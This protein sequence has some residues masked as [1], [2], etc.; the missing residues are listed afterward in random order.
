MLSE[1]TRTPTEQQL[2]VGTFV[3]L[4]WVYLIWYWSGTHGRRFAS[5]DSKDPRARALVSSLTLQNASGEAEIYIYSFARS[6]P[7]PKNTIR[8]PQTLLLLHTAMRWLL[9]QSSRFWWVNVILEICVKYLNCKS[10]RIRKR[11]RR[12]GGNMRV[13]HISR[14]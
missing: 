14:G 4:R 8:F 5:D 10:D 3:Y 2:R 12:C 9:T 13:R 6:R 7:A 11:F 1:R